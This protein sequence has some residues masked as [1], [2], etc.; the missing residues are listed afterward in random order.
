MRTVWN[1]IDPASLA[2]NGARGELR[3]RFG[4]RDEDFVLVAIANPRRQKRLERL[5]PILAICS[6]ASRR[7]GH[8]SS[9]PERP[10]RGSIDAEAAADTLANA[11]AES[12]VREDIQWIGAVREIGDVLA[13]GDVLISTSAHEGLSLVHLEALAAG[14]PV[15]ATDV[16]GTR[17]IAEECP[18]DDAAS[19][20]RGRWRIRRSA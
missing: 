19:T 12:P 4:W 8:G 13:A 20:G 17:E 3:S 9:S 10:A 11:I 5:P 7:D 15:L 14:L 6:N 18:G 16:G 1:G 2:V